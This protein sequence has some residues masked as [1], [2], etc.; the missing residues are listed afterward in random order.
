[1]IALLAAFA[2]LQQVGDPPAALTVREGDKVGSIPVVVTRLGAMV[3]A[4]DLL[5]PLGAVLLRD[6]PERFRLVIGGT[7]ME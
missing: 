4:Q 7:E 6:A 1:M 5:A 3:R 2:L